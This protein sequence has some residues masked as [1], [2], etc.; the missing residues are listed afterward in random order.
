MKQY[1]DLL[2]TCTAM[3]LLIIPSVWWR[4]RCRCCGG[5]LKLPMANFFAIQ[6]PQFPTGAS[7]RRNWGFVMSRHEAC[8]CKLDVKRE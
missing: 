8:E 6:L 3:V 1:K 5:F 2:N 4:S 7:H